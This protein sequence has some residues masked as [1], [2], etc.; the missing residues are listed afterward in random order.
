MTWALAIPAYFGTTWGAIG[1]GAAITA[2]VAGT[3]I[4]AYG[5]IQSGQAQAAMARR[6]A[7]YIRQMARYNAEVARR[8]AEAARRN[9]ETIKQVGETEAARHRQKSSDLLAQYRAGWETDAKVYLEHGDPTPFN[10]LAVMPRFE[11]G[12]K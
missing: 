4:S 9:A 6:N 3:G 11:Q 2:G 8:G 12:E 7:I 10:V 5:A 1:T